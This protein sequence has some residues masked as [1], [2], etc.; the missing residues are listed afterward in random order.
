[1]YQV[2]YSQK[3]GGNFLENRINAQDFFARGTQHVLTFIMHF[4]LA[5]S[6]DMAFD[7]NHVAQ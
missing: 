3:K 6:Y 2:T 4:L 5:S 7:I 1:M